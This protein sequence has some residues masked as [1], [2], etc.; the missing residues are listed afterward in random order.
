MAV[1]DKGI[2]GKI[3]N[4]FIAGMPKSGTTALYEYLRAHPNIFMSSLKEPHFFATDLTFLFAKDAPYRCVD[5]L[6][7]YLKL[8]ESVSDKHYAVGEASIWY[9]FSK[10][11]IKNIYKFNNKAKIIAILRNPLD[12]V[13]SLHS[14]LVYAFNE[15]EKD[16]KKAWY[17]QKERGKGHKLPKQGVHLGFLQYA[18]VG[19]LGEHVERL[20][21]I[22]P[23]EQVKLILFDDFKS[24]PKAVYEDV[25]SFLEVP[26]DGR[27]D[28]PPP[29]NE[30]PVHKIS[31]LG[32]LFQR[33]P[34]I[35]RKIIKALEKK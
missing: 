33:P 13:Y 28:F 34:R 14:Y 23:N 17:L 31:W 21:Y 3:P 30:N 22:F 6:D 1:N 26:S 29:V 19:K 25:L 4:F 35:L 32:F 16:F 9:L 8:F 7:E 15:N 20:K 5:N 12:L 10:E 2:K 11:A 24:S 18:Q 27:T